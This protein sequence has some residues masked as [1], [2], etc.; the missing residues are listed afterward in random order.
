MVE[1]RVREGIRSVVC[2]GTERQVINMLCFFLT[3]FFVGEIGK[4]CKRL[5][6]FPFLPLI[7]ENFNKMEKIELIRINLKGMLGV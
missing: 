1:V 5:P 2:R 7:R 6:I 3:F 4:D